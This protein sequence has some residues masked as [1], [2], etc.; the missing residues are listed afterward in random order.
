VEGEEV[1]EQGMHVPFQSF[2]NSQLK[3]LIYN[4]H[5][6]IFLNFFIIFIQ[7]YYNIESVTYYRCAY[8]KLITVEVYE[9]N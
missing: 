4:R 8:S 5:C 9:E 6:A 3:L 2:L 1:L 7:S